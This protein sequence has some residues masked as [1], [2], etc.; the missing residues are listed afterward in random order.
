[1]KINVAQLIFQIFASFNIIATKV[2]YYSKTRTVRNGYRFWKVEG[3]EDVS[4]LPIILFIH[5]YI[6]Q[7][8]KYFL[9]VVFKEIL[10]PKY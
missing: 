4:V 9:T 6:T 10:V 1:M 7:N 2:V 5:S 8:S 3:N